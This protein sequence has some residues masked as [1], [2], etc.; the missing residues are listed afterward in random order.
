MEFAVHWRW[1]A[2]LCIFEKSCRKKAPFSARRGAF[3][4]LASNPEPK[5]KRGRSLMPRRRFDKERNGGYEA[6]FHIIRGYLV[7]VDFTFL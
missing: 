2:R 6:V 5:T 3:C 7:F 4:S 1:F